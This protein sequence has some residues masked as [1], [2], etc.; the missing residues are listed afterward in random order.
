MN[1]SLRIFFIAMVACGF[2]VTLISSMVWI[3]AEIHESKL[4]K[5][6]FNEF[7]LEGQQLRSNLQ[8]ATEGLKSS[9]ATLQYLLN[10]VANGHPLTESMK[11]EGNKA[12]ADSERYKEESNK[13]REKLED[14]IRK[15]KELYPQY[16][17]ELPDVYI[18]GQESTRDE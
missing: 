5:K 16:L 9:T 8:L 12:A 13:I 17:E 1:N 6:A 2:T 18:Q 10:L 7:I 14:W 15:A 3:M 11:E 4:E